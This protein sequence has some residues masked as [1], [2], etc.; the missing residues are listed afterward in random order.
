MST[1]PAELQKLTDGFTQQN[2]FIADT[3]RNEMNRRGLTREGVLASMLQGGITVNAGGIVVA[4]DKTIKAANPASPAIPIFGDHTIDAVWMFVV[5]PS[6]SAVSAGGPIIIQWHLFT[7]QGELTLLCDPDVL[8]T[9]PALGR[10]ASF[11]GSQLAVRQLHRYDWLW[12]EV[13][14]APATNAPKL[15]TVSLVWEQP[16]D[17]K[18]RR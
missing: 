16:S 7:A 14:S 11:A 6:D 10:R 12:L 17:T 15:L 4:F 3:I 1:D 5:T 8:P 18:A 2:R 13:V 9:I